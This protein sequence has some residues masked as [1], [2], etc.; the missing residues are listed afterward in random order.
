M[1]LTIAA[2]T[3][4][5]LVGLPAQAQ[6]IEIK[7]AYARAGSPMAKAGAA[8]MEIHNSGSVEDRLIGASTPSAKRVEIHTH[9]MVDG[10]ARMRE[11]EGGLVIGADDT[12]I[13][14]R[15][16]DHV[17]MMGLTHAF[18]QGIEV[19]LTLEFE[20]AGEVTITVPVDLE[21]AP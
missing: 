13:L 12:A 4:A 2:V 1:K 9:I 21:R 19:I 11:I 20:R 8:F 15:G 6:T 17:M 3:A 14:E 7:D 10:V 18:E 5:F 16:G